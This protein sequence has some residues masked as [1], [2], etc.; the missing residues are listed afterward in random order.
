MTSA[1]L[2]G[3]GTDPDTGPAETVTP[4][5]G[6]RSQRGALARYLLVRL[7]LIIPTVL[8]LVTVVFFLMRVVGDPV[9]AA[10]G[11]RLNPAQI[12]ERKPP[13][14]WTGPSWCSTGST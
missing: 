11:G 8:I 5:K 7:L 10:L 9:T 6:G 2:A 13:L 3:I 1:E 14:G 12:A 4:G